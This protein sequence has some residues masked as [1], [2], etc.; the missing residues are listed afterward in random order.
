MKVRYPGIF[1]HCIGMIFAGFW[2]FRTTINN[3]WDTAISNEL[4][5]H[6]EQ[7]IHQSSD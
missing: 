4:K 5:Y 6:Q 1:I 2:F 7:D 3:Q